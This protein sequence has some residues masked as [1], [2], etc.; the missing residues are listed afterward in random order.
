MAAATHNHT[1]F[2]PYM[3]GP[4]T[5]SV[6][7]HLIIVVIAIV[8]LPYIKPEL[9]VIDTPITVELIE[10][11]ETEKKQEKTKRQPPQQLKKK[12]PKPVAPQ[13]VAKK[14]PR[15]VA[16]KPP[17]PAEIAKPKKPPPKPAKPVE[18]EEQPDEFKS[19]LRN[20]MPTEETP[21]QDAK[22]RRGEQ[23]SLMTR[24]SAKMSVNELASLKSQLSQCWSVMSGA[25]YAE[26]L[27]VD[28]KLFMNP[29]RTVRDV[30]IENRLRYST[31]SYFRAA[32]DSAQRAIFRCSPLDLPPNKY[33]L[34]KT[35]TVTFDPRSML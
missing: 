8:G 7:F 16:P 29:D 14:P 11:P 3:K 5:G 34:W 19:L 28:L 30:R 2:E 20:L 1:F 21:V 18:E 13:M 25:R 15:P 27:V 26:D 32:A 17:V 12:P 31:D 23:S 35:I 6:V 9:P 24:F 33:D 22:P 4:L 10:A